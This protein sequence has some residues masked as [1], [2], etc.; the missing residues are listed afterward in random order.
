[1][2]C[3]PGTRRLYELLCQ[4][5]SDLGITVREERRGGVSDANTIAALGVPVLDG[6]GP[7]GDRDHSTEEFMLAP[8]L[9][10]RVLL[11]TLLVLRCLELR[12]EGRW[13]A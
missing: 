2:E 1:M 6:L 4:C 5:G 8:S 3:G 10:E 9:R 7:A 13:Q 11:G 12:R